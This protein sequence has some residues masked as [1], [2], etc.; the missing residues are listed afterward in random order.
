MCL[1]EKEKHNVF[2]Q[3]GTYDQDRRWS[4]DHPHYCRV[5]ALA[6]FLLWRS[7]IDGGLPARES[8]PTLLPRRSSVPVVSAHSFPCVSL[9]SGHW[10]FLVQMRILLFPLLA[11]NQFIHPTMPT[12][13]YADFACVKSYSGTLRMGGSIVRRRISILRTVSGV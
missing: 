2:S 7:D 3:A 10:V 4:G 9:L 5:C 11:Y 6:P 8:F 13:S 1:F 12:L